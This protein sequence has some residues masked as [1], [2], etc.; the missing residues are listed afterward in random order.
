MSPEQR[1]PAGANRAQHVIQPHDV[2]AV[3]QATSEPE[4]LLA[5]ASRGDEILVKRGD[6]AHLGQAKHLPREV[7]KL[8]VEAQMLTCSKPSVCQPQ[9]AGRCLARDHVASGILAYLPT[10]HCVSF[11]QG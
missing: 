1:S 3:V 11:G 4:C 2:E 5:P 6:Q 8:L 9:I 10:S 7:A